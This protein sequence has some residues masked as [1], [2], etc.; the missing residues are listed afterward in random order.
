[1]HSTILDRL[2]LLT[3][4][5]EYFEFDDNAWVWEA[6]TRFLKAD[7]A[8]LRYGVKAIKGAYTSFAK[9]GG[10]IGLLKKR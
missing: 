1:M 8:A 10:L 7:I 3:I 4:D 5:R 2:R 6:S 9:L